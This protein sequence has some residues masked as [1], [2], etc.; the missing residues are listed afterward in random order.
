MKHT[1]IYDKLGCEFEYVLSDVMEQID[2][3]HGDVTPMQDLEI[4][5]HLEALEKIMLDI[6]KQNMNE[7]FYY[8]TEDLEFYS[9][10][11]LLREFI[12]TDEFNDLFEAHIK[13]CTS[14]NGTLEE[15]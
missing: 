14:K 4:K 11:R 13:N 9:K 12:D 2:C 6:L 8:S 15:I 5:M 10:N 7:S 3:R 1:I